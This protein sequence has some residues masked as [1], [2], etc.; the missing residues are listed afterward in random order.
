M[1]LSRVMASEDGNTGKLASSSFRECR[2]ITKVYAGL[3]GMLS[4]SKVAEVKVDVYPY[5]STRRCVL[6]C[7]P[8][9]VNH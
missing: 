6:M 7:C 1:Q 8:N 2:L 9:R 4:D 5:R 3:L